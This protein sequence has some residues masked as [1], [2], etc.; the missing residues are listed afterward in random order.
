[1]SNIGNALMLKFAVIICTKNRANDLDITLNSVF[2]Q[3]LLPDIILIVD[4]SN[5]DATKQMIKKYS[6]L[7]PIE[8]NYI[9]P[10]T[11]NTGLP[12]ARN[13]GIKNVPENTDIIVFLDDDVTLDPHYFESLI[14]QFL[15]LPQVAGVGGFIL[16]GYHNRR[17]YEKPILAM[18]GFL[19]PSLVPASL[20]EF[21][22]TKTGQPLRPLYLQYSKNFGN[23]EWL[24]GSNMAY[25]TSVFK[26]GDVFDENFVRYAQGEDIVF[27]HQLYK[28]GKKLFIAKKAQLSHRV[29]LEDRIP[30][31][32]H[33][34]M[35]FGYRKYTIQKFSGVGAAGSLYYQLFVLNF[36]VAAFVLSLIRKNNFN[37]LKETIKAYNI[38]KRYEEMIGKNDL[39]SFNSIFLKSD[40]Q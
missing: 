12:A 38:F 36:F 13:C 8:I 15:A 30:S 32:K 5:N 24:S 26:E 9:R 34:I 17:W 14:E 3:T 35:I 18:I 10:T 7:S 31:L 33:L 40:I 37:Y 4:D 2:L 23:A 20:F 6:L 22:V 19:I 27:S 16:E 39:E 25:R 29:S 28:N 1:L 11:A 21:R